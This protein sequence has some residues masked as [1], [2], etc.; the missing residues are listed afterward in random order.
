MATRYVAQGEC[1]MSLLAL[2]QASDGTAGTAAHEPDYATHRGHVQRREEAEESH[3]WCREDRLQEE[4]AGALNAEDTGQKN[5]DHD[6]AQ[7]RH[8]GDHA[9]NRAVQATPQDAAGSV[10]HVSGQ[11]AARNEE[12]LN[13]LVGDRDDEPPDEYDLEDSRPLQSEARLNRRLDI[14]PSGEPRPGVHRDAETGECPRRLRVGGHQQD[15]DEEYCPAPEQ[16]EPALD[17]GCHLFVSVVGAG[18]NKR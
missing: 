14:P 9:E 1:G 11:Q 8:G 13:R 7:E 10:T 5:R 12:R 15:D 3:Y 18:R 17:G 16:D 6:E 4:S 2:G